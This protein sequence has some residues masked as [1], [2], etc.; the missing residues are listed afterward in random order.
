MPRRA[1]HHVKDRRRGRRCKLQL[2]CVGIF[3]QDS[4]QIFEEAIVKTEVQRCF[5]DWRMER[6]LHCLNDHLNCS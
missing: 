4:L 3:Y 1:V 5:G 6:N 2:Q